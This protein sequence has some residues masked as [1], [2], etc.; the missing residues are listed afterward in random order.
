MATRR[1]FRRRRR[2]LGLRSSWDEVTPA[3]GVD[4]TGRVVAFAFAILHP[5]C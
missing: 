3:D 4:L 1:S 5:I 2:G